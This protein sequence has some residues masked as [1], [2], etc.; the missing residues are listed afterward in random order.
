MSRLQMCYVT[1]DERV[2]EL[3]SYQDADRIC[4]KYIE[5]EVKR[6]KRLVVLEQLV[7]KGILT[8]RVSNA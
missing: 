4:I 3:Q 1:I 5:G 7:D 6:L 2:A 8:R